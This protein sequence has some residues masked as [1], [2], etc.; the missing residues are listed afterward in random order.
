MS[1]KLR[2]IAAAPGLCIGKAMVLNEEDYKCTRQL[3]TA[4]DVEKEVSRFGQAVETAVR[5]LQS[6]QEEVA[7]RLGES[8]GQIIGAQVLMASDPA[9][10]DS[11]LAKVVQELVS[12]ETAVDEA[13]NEQARMLEELDDE[14][15]AARAADMRDVGRRI[16]AVL[17]GTTDL[18]VILG[19]LEV[20]T[21]LVAGEL[22]PSETAAINVEKIAGIVLDRGGRTSHTAILARSL[23]IPAVMG[24]GH[25]TKV[26]SNGDLI[27][28]DGDKGE[29]T[30]NPAS[31]DLLRFRSEMDFAEC[32]K[33]RLSLLRNL[34]AVTVD[35]RRVELAANIGGAMET[36]LVES[37]GAQG[38]GLFR[39][40]FLFIE[41]NCAPSEDEQFEIYKEVLSSLEPDP[42]VV[43]TLD[44]GGDKEIP[45]LGLPQEDNPFLGLR[46]IRLCLKEKGIFKTQ[47][48]ALLRASNFGA[49]R[50]MFPMVADVQELRDARRELEN[51]RIELKSQGIIVS[52][53][54]QIGIMVE[55]PSAALQADVLAC[56]C[57]F[58]SIGTNDLV[59]Y[60]MAADRGNPA[61]GYLSDP[62]YPPVLRLISRT[63]EE[64]HKNGIWV[65]MCGEMAGMLPAIPLLVGMGIDELSMAPAS[66]PAA[67]GIIRS[68][69]HGNAIDI[70][71]RVQQMTDRNEIRAYLE[72][73]V[74][75]LT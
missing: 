48:R 74:N 40:E 58:F 61:V 37:Y 44:A 52:D 46:A 7:A 19:S 30:I 28:I 54:I 2:G 57:D 27:L 33:R 5:Q 56:E 38:V 42:V 13:C 34:P 39:T 24:L 16:I 35:G 41:R 26:V 60:T 43:R 17:T 1:S 59:Q 73:L 71:N 23:G 70:W 47:L 6:L 10:A 68:L 29:A 53:K 72:D 4:P 21:I 36:G 50:I 62:F 22:T 67:K 20:G 3:I 63:I 8:E 12:A 31:D 49:L 55:V 9:L 32:R 69:N 45:Y 64:G 11:V 66:V 14:Y 25:A 75:N 18:G 65:G 15:L 51:A